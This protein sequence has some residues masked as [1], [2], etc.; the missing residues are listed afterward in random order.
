MLKPALRLMTNYRLV[1]DEIE[2]SRA[3]TS[4]TRWVDAV[5]VRGRKPRS[6]PNFQSLLRAHMVR[7][8][9]AT[10]RLRCPEA[11]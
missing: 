1:I 7:S 5:E 9:E 10:R 2:G 6:L 3:I 8:E 4:Y 11:G